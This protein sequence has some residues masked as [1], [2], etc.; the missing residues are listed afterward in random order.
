MCMILPLPFH[1]QRARK[2]ISDQ[3]QAEVTRYKNDVEHSSR[4]MEDFRNELTGKKKK[5]NS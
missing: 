3:L 4:Q 2:V 5:A 1:E